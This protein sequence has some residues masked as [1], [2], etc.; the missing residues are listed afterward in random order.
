[1]TRVS[2]RTLL[3]AAAALSLPAPATRAQGSGGVALVIGNSKYQWE[4]PLP[5]VKRDAPDI[6]KRMQGMGLKTELVQDAGR[7]AMRQAIDKFTAA[8]RGAP[9]AALY[10]AGHGATWAQET[11]LVPVDADLSNPAAAKTLVP[12]HPLSAALGEAASRLMVFDSCRNNPADGW[13]QREAEQTASFRLGDGDSLAPNTLILFSTAPGRV[14]VDGPAGENSP[15][16]AALLRRLGAPSVDLQ[17]LAPQLRRDLL[18]A[19]Q[20]RQVLWDSNSFRQPFSLKGA[21]GAAPAAAGGWAG[22]PSKI[23]ELPN[24]YAFAQQNNLPLPAGLIAHRPAGNSRDSQKIGA[25]RYTSFGNNAGLIVVMSVEE[26]QT[27]EVIMATRNPKEGFRFWRFVRG[28]ISGDT[29][30]Y[31]PKDQGAPR[32]SFRWS[33]ANGGNVTA[34]LPQGAA[35]GQA[36]THSKFTRLDG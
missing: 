18:I 4:A 21:G 26:Q 8:S 30:E 35:M 24:A 12:A 9:L 34:Q 2:R 33:D 36:S 31:L 6:A 10:F 23:V 11:Y 1:M 15:F 27:A 14:A 20:G 29:L 7:D 28:N 17:S 3:G 22:D 13:R 16:A 32:L 5:N 19:T 25:F